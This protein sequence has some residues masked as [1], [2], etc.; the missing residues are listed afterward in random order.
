MGR[1]GMWISM[2]MALTMPV[3][4]HA[5]GAYSFTNL[6]AGESGAYSVVV[7]NR[8]PASATASAVLTVLP[9]P[10]LDDACK[11]N[12]TNWSAFW[13][14]WEDTSAGVIDSA[15]HVNAGAGS[16]RCDTG[17]GFDTGVTP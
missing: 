2:W 6:P 9:T 11:G 5:T 17:S 10:F 7:S 1:W 13:P 12:A 8:M 4:L 14:D 3:L 16:V 15:D